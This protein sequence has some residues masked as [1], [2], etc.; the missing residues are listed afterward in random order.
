[1]VFIVGSAW[2]LVLL[3]MK[4]ILVP[5]SLAKVIERGL[6]SKIPFEEEYRL[7]IECQI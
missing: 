7:F 5:L 2:F 1:M 3:K 6:G 4:S